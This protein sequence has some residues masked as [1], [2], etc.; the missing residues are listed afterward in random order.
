ME[1]VQLKIKKEFV[2]KKK[3]FCSQFGV[4][5]P[6]YIFFVFL[7]LDK[8]RNL[9]NTWSI[10]PRTIRRQILIFIS[11]FFYDATFSL[12]LVAFGKIE[13]IDVMKSE[14]VCA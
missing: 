12:Y 4:L 6:F 2:R 3:V 13:K 11:F 9:R 5:L 14:L 10:N 8:L 1:V 7:L